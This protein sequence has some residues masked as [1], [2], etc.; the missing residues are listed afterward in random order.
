MSPIRRFCLGTIKTVEF[1]N[2]SDRKHDTTELTSYSYHNS[3]G[4][5]SLICGLDPSRTPIVAREPENQALHGT[6]TFSLLPSLVPC[7]TA[8]IPL[9]EARYFIKL[10][11]NAE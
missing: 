6:I 8:Q 2:R 11:G 10:M 9:R 5:Y 4:A 3:Y 7:Q 1:E